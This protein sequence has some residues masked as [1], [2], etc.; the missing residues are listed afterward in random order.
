MDES[1]GKEDPSNGGAPDGSTSHDTKMFDES[2]QGNNSL[3]Q[4]LSGSIL[5]DEAAPLRDSQANMELGVLKTALDKANE[6]IRLLHEKL[7]HETPEEERDE[8]PVVGLSGGNGSKMAVAKSPEKD[9][10]EERQTINVRMLNGENFVTEWGNLTTPLPPPPDHGL[11]SPIIDVVLE[12]WTDDQGLHES[13]LNW[14]ERVMT[15]DNLEETVPPLTLSSLDHQVRDGFVMHLLPLLLRRADIHVNVQTRAHRTTTYDLAVSVIQTRNPANFS[16]LVDPRSPSLL[17]QQEV[18]DDDDHSPLPHNAGVQLGEDDEVEYTHFRAASGDM[19]D[20]QPT[21][22]GALG[23]ALGGLLSRGRQ[24]LAHSPAR[25]PTSSSVALQ[26]STQLIMPAVSSGSSQGPLGSRVELDS[27]PY[28]RV[29]SAPPGRIGVTFVEYRGHAMVADMAA[30]SPLSSW[31]FPSD[32]LIAVDEV[33]VSGMRIR[34]IIK[35]L[36]NRKDRQRALRVISSHAMNEFT[37]NQSASVDEA[38]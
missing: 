13:L 3:F 10:G 21:F 27:Q 29:V 15:G 14:M 25:S 8:A 31:V 23:G 20:V 38:M 5:Q 4:D 1:E 11:R 18:G 7:H 34:D 26:S 12:Q 35:I 33:P 19:D 32:I 24:T 16:R 6:T 2:F 30:D 36:T 28:H 9:G 22:M 17:D 37:L